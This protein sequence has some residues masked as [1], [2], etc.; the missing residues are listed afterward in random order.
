MLERTRHPGKLYR[1]F[2]GYKTLKE[3][4]IEDEIREEF[5]VRALKHGL[6]RIRGNGISS[7]NISEHPLGFWTGRKGH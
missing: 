6:L 1:D 3:N 4:D 7:C 5:A 2:G